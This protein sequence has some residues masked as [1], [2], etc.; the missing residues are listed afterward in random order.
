MSQ[1]SYI[2][3]ATKAD[4]WRAEQHN[5]AEQ[6]AL[7]CFHCVF[8][9]LVSCTLA[10]TQGGT[11]PPWKSIYLFYYN[12][13]DPPSTIGKCWIDV[14]P[15]WGCHPNFLSSIHLFPAPYSQKLLECM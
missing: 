6:A 9:R 15:N 5:R 8:C 10:Q 3:L 12:L 14:F 11:T 13:C 4:S 2:I 7:P 1:Y